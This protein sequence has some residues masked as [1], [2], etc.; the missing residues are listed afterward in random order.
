[1]TI[2]PKHRVRMEEV[3]QTGT[4]VPAKPAAVEEPVEAA[5]EETEPRTE[6][7]GPESEVT[8]FEKVDDAPGESGSRDCCRCSG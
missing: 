6:E 3:I 5:S 8:S 1:M 4:E 2:E 7:D